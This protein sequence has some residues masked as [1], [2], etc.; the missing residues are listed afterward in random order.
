MN[1]LREELSGGSSRKAINGLVEA[2]SLSPHLIDELFECIRLD[3]PKVSWHAAWVTEKLHEQ[4]PHLFSPR[5]LDEVVDILLQ[6]NNDSIRRHL[7]CIL[8]VADLPDR[9]PVGLINKAFEWIL[10]E[11]IAVAVKSLS[12]HYLLKVCSAEKELLP[13]L[14]LTVS[15]ALESCQNPAVN[16]AAKRVFKAYRP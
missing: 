2:A 12:I 4:Y 14:Y 1:S 3:I 10:S 6:T 8:R 11:K 15:H 5:M 7:L 16:S 13:E 9:L